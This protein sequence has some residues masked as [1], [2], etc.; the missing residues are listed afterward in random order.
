[1]LI[2]KLPF[3]QLLV[4]RSPFF[5]IVRFSHLMVFSFLGFGL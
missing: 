4:K 2:D 3:N 1:L 5:W